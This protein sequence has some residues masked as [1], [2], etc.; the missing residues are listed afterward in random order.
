MRHLNQR[1]TKGETL[2]ETLVAV[3]VCAL[4]IVMLLMATTTATDLNKKAEDRDAQL[5]QEQI[6]AEYGDYVGT[7]TVDLRRQDL[8]RALSW[9]TMWSPTRS[10]AGGTSMLTKIPGI[11]VF[12][13]W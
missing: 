10:R 6:A 12:S 1:N 2:V 3:L 11:A 9:E 13:R 4:S 7:A 8:R 5:N